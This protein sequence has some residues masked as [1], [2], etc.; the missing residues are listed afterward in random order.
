LIL[1][2]LCALIIP[3]TYALD[4]PNAP[5]HLDDNP[6][7][8]LSA[9]TG[10]G[11]DNDS[12]LEFRWGGVPEAKSY[13]VYLSIDGG[14]FQLESA[15]FAP[16]Y[17][18]Q[19]VNGHFYQIRVTSMANGEES[20]A[21]QPSNRIVVDTA[22]PEMPILQ[23][24][25][26]VLVSTVKFVVPLDP[27]TRTSDD[28]NFDAY[29]LRGGQFADWTTTQEM[30]AFEF[31]LQPNT[32]NALQIRGVDL[33]GNPSPVAA[34][35][36]IQDSVPP[37]AP[38]LAPLNRQ[39][40]NT[41][42]IGLRVDVPSLD[43][44]FSH[45]QLRGGQ[46]QNWTSVSETA[47]FSFE[48]ARNAENLLNVRGVD[49]AGNIG[50]AVTVR[51]I[52]DAIPPQAPGQPSAREETS[53]GSGFARSFPLTWE[54][55]PAKDNFR[56]D[57][58]Q[59]FVLVDSGNLT[60]AGS[61]PTASFPLA[62]TTGRSYQVRVQAVDAAGN[63][64][65]FSQL[66]RPIF[67][68]M[69]SPTTPSIRIREP[70]VLPGNLVDAD[71]ILV[72][73]VV[74]SEDDLFLG[75]QLLGGQY[76]TWTGTTETTTF[77]FNLIQDRVNIL[78]VR[79]SDKAGNVSG[80]ATIQVIEDSTP[81]TPPI[82]RSTRLATRENSVVV[83]LVAPSVDPFF[84]GYEL[85]GGQYS[86]WTRTPETNQFRFQLQPDQINRLFIRA[87]DRLGH[88]SEPVEVQAV[89]DLIPPARPGVPLHF[90][91][92]A[93]TIG[94]DDDTT[95]DF[96]WTP[97][98]DDFA[99][100]SNY[101]VFL[102]VDGLPYE[103]IGKSFGPAFSVAVAEGHVYRLQV[104]AVDQASNVGP[105]SEASLPVL[106]DTTPP[107]SPVIEPVL[108]FTSA[109]EVELQ[110]TT[111]GQS[112]DANGVKYQIRGGKLDFWMDVSTTGPFRFFLAPNA[113][114]TLSIRAV[115][116]AGN[117]SVNSVQ[118]TQ[119]SI[120]PSAPS[121][122]GHLKPEEAFVPNLD[123]SSSVKFVWPPAEDN[124]EVDYYQ[125]QVSRNGGA[126]KPDERKIATPS[127]QSPYTAAGENGNTYQ[128][129][130][131]A[132]DKAGNVSPES[133]P[134][135]VIFVD[136]EPPVVELV[137]ILGDHRVTG[138]V[139]KGDGR[140]QLKARIK[141]ATVTEEG[142]AVDFSQLTGNAAD[143][144]VKPLAK[145]LSVFD[146]F[147]Q[148]NWFTSLSPNLQG[149]RVLT[150]TVSASDNAGNLSGKKSAQAVVFVPPASQE[151][152]VTVS[153]DG[154]ANVVV[155]L[156]PSTIPDKR[157]LPIWVVVEPAVAE[158]D[159]NLPEQTYIPK[160]SKAYQIIAEDL[161]GVPIKAEQIRDTFTL[162]L[163]YSSD[164]GPEVAENLRLFV[165]SGNQWSPVTSQVDLSGRMVKTEVASEFGIYRVLV[166]T[167]TE[168]R[169][170][171]AYPNP[172]RFENSNRTLKFRNIPPNAEIE[173]YT[174]TGEKIK[175]IKVAP[176]AP[177]VSWDGKKDNGDSV[178]SGL[179][180]YRIRLKD[181]EMFGKIAVL[182]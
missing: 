101:L 164:I 7:A 155:E 15:V 37:T 174:V 73:L 170:I 172:I 140:V 176:N 13:N 123:N 157:V 122:P 18:L 25:D 166:Q 75:Y 120:P 127:A 19:G 2:T 179:Y 114:N 65:D 121:K 108:P 72:E 130:V 58:Y 77:R 145:N 38:I 137:E 70:R 117:Q 62:V 42:T 148:V 41:P 14:G 152:V 5:I 8:N 6:N 78:S 118:V 133:P 134:S 136:T 107:T 74:P 61:T 35:G 158:A 173:I 162:G 163:G 143:R 96:Q 90:D 80:T 119:D 4:P 47:V 82:V 48:L 141:D 175:K 26:P 125:A 146:N 156:K 66:S 139:T 31:Q 28:P 95:L 151:T 23:F 9:K 53:P 104:A 97:A 51:A 69:T 33:A 60:L 63:L 71:S 98:Q 49:K 79:G 154:V 85:R 115:D 100:V 126:F 147:V 112:F 92:T 46:Y 21:S 105:R 103:E 160:G 91:S 124:F 177:Q 57:S 52:H 24:K 68:D 138:K 153:K 87:I 32:T 167:S 181:K 27:Q 84:D 99:A 56:V 128:I 135:E 30:A 45:Y 10:L 12:I 44:H 20:E 59:V 67:V 22:P 29:Q 11:Y 111:D 149:G 178:T 132:V 150:V 1:S 159:Q 93:A 180:I 144:A 168:L 129:K 34:L 54:W 81:P 116:P 171:L 64:G 17:T 39:A 131:R 89:Q 16:Q 88:R 182:R 36:V 161:L 43:P 165:L 102:S 3:S 55:G 113:E 142:I 106:V 109:F 76:A 40:V 169:D 110:L 86:D 94:F 50:E 83:E